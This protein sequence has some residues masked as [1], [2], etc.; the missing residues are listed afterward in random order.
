LY[1]EELLIIPDFKTFQK[2]S[3]S[4]NRVTFYKE[5]A[6]DIFTPVSILKNFSNE[7]NFFLFESA[8]IDKTFSRFSFFSKCPENVITFK[9]NSQNPV[10]YIK[11]KLKK[12]KVFTQSYLG[13]F[14]GGILGFFGYESVNYMNVLKTPIK[15]SSEH[16]I[17]A[18]MEINKFYVFDNFRNKLYAAFSS[19]ISESTEKTFKKAEKVLTELT[20]NIFSSNTVSVASEKIEGSIDFAKEYSD[21]E[22]VKKIKSIKNEIIEG[23]AIQVVFS[24]KYVLN[25][26]IN[27]VSFYRAVRN[28]NPSPYL[29]YLKFKNFVLTGS[30][31]ETH[32]KINNGKAL[33]KPIAGT[34]PVSSKKNIEDIKKSLL[35]DKKE[36]S[37]HLMLL[38]LARNDLFQG[39]KCETVKVTKAFSTEVYSH[40]IHIVSEV[41]GILAPD[42]TPFELF[43]K[44][45]PAG[46]VSGA[47]KVRAIELIDKYEKSARGFYSG[48]VG[49]FGYSGNIDTCIT[50]RSALIEENKIT[51]RA[52]AGIVYDSIPEKELLEVE[53]KLGALFS[54][55]KLIKNIED[56][57][58]F[59][60]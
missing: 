15:E 46:T 31:P 44:T 7:E 13:D 36:Y 19:K 58:V 8:N 60:N 29:F 4:Y 14:T 30:S 28:I 3:L 50:I 9:G 12:E 59:V 20:K 38:D 27:P 52:G 32:L 43:T 21:K 49:Y 17:A 16:I 25:K 18:F 24:Q 6:G 54:A 26:R 33:L 48:C 22:F 40:V 2:I 5:I 39:C 35:N 10:E 55:L 1:K 45:F 57:N 23:E 34:Y 41:E 42:T 56:K 51:L 11:S 53:K 37:E 47:P